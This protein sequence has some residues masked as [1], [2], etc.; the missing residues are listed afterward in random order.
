[1]Q[2]LLEANRIIGHY[3]NRIIYP[4]DVAPTCCKCDEFAKYEVLGDLYCSSCIWDIAIEDNR[5]ENELC[6]YCG[7]TIDDE[8]IKIRGDAY[9]RKCF[10]LSYSID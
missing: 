5:N 8:C 2:S 6:E 9:H 4:Q 1:M 10:D 3:S 7:E